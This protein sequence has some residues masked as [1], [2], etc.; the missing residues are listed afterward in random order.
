LFA[1]VTTD[2]TRTAVGLRS[3]RGPILAAVMLSTALVAIDS[4]ILAAAVPAIVTDLGGFTQFPWLFSIYLL[5]QAVS[6]PIYGKLADS[7][8]RKPVML[9]GIGLFLLGS[10]LCG[11]A[12]SMPLLIAARAVQGL[13]AGATLPMSMTIV[14]DIYTVEERARVQGFIASVWG[15]ASV[16]GPTLGGVFSDYLSWRWIFFVNLPI[17][18][19]A[20]VMLVRHLH[21]HLERR[22][23]RIDYAGSALLAVGG[24]LLVLALLQGGHSWAW[25]SPTSIVLLGVSAAALAVFPY[26]ERRAAEPVLPLWVFSRRVLVAANTVSLLVGAVL[27]GLTSYVP[28][29]AQGVLGFG[30]LLSGFALAAMTIGWPIAAS[31]S[32]RI[33]LRVGFRTTSLIGVAFIVLGSLLLL[34]IGER[35]SLWLVAA[36][37]FLVGVGLGYTASPTLVAVQSVVGWERRG[38]VTATNM[39]ARSIGSAVGVAVFGAIANSSLAHRL[40]DPPQGVTGRLPR[41]ADDASLILG[42]GSHVSPRVEQFVRAALST[43]THH[44]FV[45]VAVLAVVMVAAVLL[46]PRHV[47]ELQLDD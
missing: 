4:T 18:A 3:E 42:G 38:V 30:A 44:V 40:A 35:S 45:G 14:G 32:G 1:V 28:T 22:R 43:A 13:G 37:T 19:F 8:G 9:A 33:Y 26:V 27:I 2:V 5:A 41:S 17:G 47:V 31:T 6:V 20:T 23:H 7:V 34:T 36:Y 21:E 46:M 29:F 10:V 16:V 15:I 39:F 12:W 24:S 11:V 25:D